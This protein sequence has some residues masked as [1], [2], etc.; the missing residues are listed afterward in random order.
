VKT[1]F[2]AY[3]LAAL[4]VGAFTG[5]RATDGYFSI[6]YGMKASG[7]GGAAQGFTDDAF[8]GANNPAS[9]VW[10]GNRVDVGATLFDPERGAS[11]SGSAGAFGP[12]DPGRDF[13]QSSDSTRFV[14]PE[15]AIS[16]ALSTD[17]AV[18]VSVYGNGG[19][20]TN[21]SGNAFSGFCPQGPGTYNALCGQGRLGVNLS[22][23]LI[24][25]TF[26]WRIDSHQSIG[27]AP[28]LGVQVFK[29]YG[30]QAFAASSSAP[31]SLTDNGADSS[32]GYGARIGYML[33]PN[34][35]W[36]IGASYAS[37]VYM[38][39]LTHYEGLFA[40]GGKFDI[41]SNW[42]IGVA[43]KPMSALTIG[44]DFERI[45]YSDIP[46]VHNPS[47]NQMP[48]GSSGGPGFG[49]NS[50]NVYKL[51]VEFAAS[52]QMT[53]RVGFNH[54]DDPVTARD[55]TF[56]ILAPGV[57]QDHFTG[58]LTYQLSAHGEITGMYM[59]AFAHSVSGASL[60]FGGT[61]QI[62]MYQNAYGVAYAHKF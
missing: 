12:M 32:Y 29:S 48:L 35:Q 42:S 11:R 47:T 39:R 56:N 44:L 50:I 26:A 23:G 4:G 40:E 28:V 49:W 5:A 10:V 45:N 43:Y 37:R 31:G 21:Y 7:R 15:F 13:N 57:V 54:G 46:S 51:G 61:E 24:A 41:P 1:K 33:R 17:F 22:Q 2:S 38:S 60:I 8:G 62:H 25:P 34:E 55:V 27:I 59:H 36:S 30:L 9:I 14:I 52:E 6:G 20:N 53:W 18:G 19:L 16:H 3:L 58:G